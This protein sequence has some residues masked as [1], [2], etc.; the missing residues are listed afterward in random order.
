[1]SDKP[2]PLILEESEEEM[3]KHLLR[4]SKR[5]TENRLSYLENNALR[6]NNDIRRLKFKVQELVTQFNGEREKLLSTLNSLIGDL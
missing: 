6:T 5:T 4:L 3:T 2:E 1:M